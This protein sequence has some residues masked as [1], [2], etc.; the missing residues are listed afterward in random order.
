MS[1]AEAGVLG[2]CYLSAYVAL[3]DTLGSGDTIYIPGG[4]GGVGHLAIQKAKAL[5]AKLVISSGGSADSRALALSSGADFVF[6]YCG[7]DI[8]GE[9]RHLTGGSG[10][11]LVFDA[12]YNEQS[13]VDTSRLVRAGD[14]WVVLGVGPGRTS[15]TVSP[16]TDILAEK[17]ATLVNFILLR[18]FSEPGALDEAVITTLSR[19]LADAAS[20]RVRPH[21]SKAIPSDVDA[22]N[23]ALATMKA[24]DRTLGKIA[25]TLVVEQA[26]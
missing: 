24:G 10:V 2:I 7:D 26:R 4:G 25:V 1:F 6:N 3:T 14:R 19:G 20:G 8:A 16:V 9:I 15:D 22:I 23:A 11:D 5:G 12:T 21:I 18:L 13:F 17:N